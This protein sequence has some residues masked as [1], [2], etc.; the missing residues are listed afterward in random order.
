MRDLSTFLFFLFAGIYVGFTQNVQDATS[1]TGK[2]S[3]EYNRNALTV[4]VLDNNN[5][6]IS[7]LK[8]AS[9][10]IVIP[11]KFD[12]NLLT[13]RYIS[14]QTSSKAVESALKDNHIPNEIIAKWF[15]RTDDGKM[16]MNV[17]YDRG[18]YNATDDEI[19]QAS[20]SKLG[21]AKV[22]DAGEIL[23]NHSYILVLAFNKIEDMAEKYDKQDAA[24][25]AL[26]KKMGTDYEPVKRR[27]NGWEG[28]VTAYLY[29]INF[30]DSIIDEFYNDM[31]IYDDDDAATIAAKKEKFDNARF[32]ISFITVASGDAD[33]SQYNQGEILA[34][35]KQL[36]RDE[37]FQKMINTGITNAIFDI[38]RKV[39]EFRVKTPLYGSSPLKAKIGRKEGLYTEQRYFVYEFE[40]KSNGDTKA[41]RKG[42]VR[43]KKVVDNKQVA[44]GNSDLYTTFYQTSGR[45]LMA[46][47]L[48]QQR[49]DMGIGISGGMSSGN[50]GGGFIKAEGNIGVLTGR[51]MDLGLTQVKIFGTMHIQTAEYNLGSTLYSGTYDMTFTRLQVGLSKGWYFARN[52]SISPYISYGMETATSDDWRTDYGLSDDQN[53]GTDFIALGAFASMNLV[54]WFQIIGGVNIYTPFGD[55]YDKDRNSLGVAYTDIFNGRSGLSLDFGVRIEF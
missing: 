2:V 40:Q 38:E 14:S 36:T 37:L 55:A 26:A 52:F 41:K 13:T 29:K 35:P 51:I 53:I 4:I 7:D 39:E 25:K 27:K 34:P 3:T 54:N 23:L 24:K 20:G 12:D 45:A 21:L 8:Q 46:G 5:K 1:K 11:G 32:P 42:V 16:S 19:K 30:A 43:A 10:G 28:E 48:L 22:K 9:S 47:M 31:W 6:F 18:L 15:S 44:T 49:N 17:I 50:M 33:G